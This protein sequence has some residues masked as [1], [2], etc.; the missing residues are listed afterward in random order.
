MIISMYFRCQTL[1]CY[2]KYTIMFILYFFVITSIYWH[3]NVLCTNVKWTFLTILEGLNSRKI[4]Y[5]WFFNFVILC[6]MKKKGILFF[7]FFLFLGNLKKKCFSVRLLWVL[8]G[9]SVFSSPP[10]RP[11]NSDFEGFCIPDFIQYIYFTILI[12]VWRNMKKMG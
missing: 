11:M 8:H 7:L 4:P 9:H 3:K 10:Q 12:L 1:S 5:L 2:H 6:Y